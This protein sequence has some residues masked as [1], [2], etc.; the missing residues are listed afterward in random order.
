MQS[1]NNAAQ[2]AYTPRLR[3]QYNLIL[4]ILFQFAGEKKVDIKKT[5][6]RIMPWMLG[7]MPVARRALFRAG[8]IIWACHSKSACFQ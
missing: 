7:T 1:P 8:V 2:D 4:R 3:C 6:R 5:T